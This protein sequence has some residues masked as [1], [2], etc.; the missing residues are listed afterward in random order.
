VGATGDSNGDGDEVDTGEGADARSGYATSYEANLRWTIGGGP[1][2]QVFRF[3][4]RGS[5]W[6][7]GALPTAA[8]AA[9]GAG[10]GGPD[11]VWNVGDVYAETNWVPTE[12]LLVQFGKLQGGAWSSPF[13][14]VYLIHNAIGASHNEYWMNWSGVDGLDIE[15]NAGAFQVGVGLSSEC[16]PGCGKG[17]YSTSTMVPHIAGKFGD[18]AF[19]VSVPAT[20]AK[21]ADADETAQGGSGYQAGVGWSGAGIGV[22]FDIQSFT[23]TEAGGADTEDEARSGMVLR[24]DVA[25]ITI[26]Y[27]T[28]AVKDAAGVLDAETSLTQ[29]VV[30]YG[31]KVG[32]GTIYPEYS[33]VTKSNATDGDAYT[34]TLLRL[35]GNLNF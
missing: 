7:G 33:S 23:T 6:F 28:Q 11:G 31:M 15:Y 16:K 35:V 26:G 32:E 19:R 4:P 1:L 12:G 14:G 5:N 2:T 21:A 34:N 29:I 20:S 25:G 8:A 27:H 17:V 18:I 22:G 13:G 24:V 9:T 10:G 3:R 30:R